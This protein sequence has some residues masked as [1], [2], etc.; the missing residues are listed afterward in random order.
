MLDFNAPV[1]KIKSFVN[2]SHVLEDWKNWEQETNT[3]LIHNRNPYST[4][5][6]HRKIYSMKAILN[7][8]EKYIV[9]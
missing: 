2:N 5:H 6:K 8:Q 9:I 3:L 4:P 1:K 7:F